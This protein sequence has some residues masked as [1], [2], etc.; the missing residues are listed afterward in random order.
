MR[1]VAG[2]TLLVLG[3]T[4]AFLAPFLLLYSV[5]RLE[6]A[7][8][9]TSENVVSD[10]VANY[11]SAKQLQ[12]VG[13]APVQV[14]ETLRGVP[15]K[16][17]TSVAVIAYRSRLVD[18]RTGD[19][20]SYDQETY[21]M[22]RHTGVAANCCGETPK[23]SGVTLKFPFGTQKATYQLWDPSANASFAVRY[24]RTDDL[25]G[26]SA[27]VFSGSSSDINIGTIDLPNSLVGV[28]GQGLTTE[29]EMYQAQTTVWIEPTT[30]QV[31]K[32]EKH[33]HQWAA[34]SSGTIVL[35]L[36]DL[37]VIY[38]DATVSRFVNDA[39]TNVQQLK[40][41]KQGIPLFG[42]ILGLVLAMVGLL[43][44]RRTPER[45]SEDTPVATAA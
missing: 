14:V 24:A 23:M 30:G 2:Y 8:T 37:H 45:A 43:L 9:D 17:T 5:P 6:K 42:G 25:K 7:P 34:D 39:K 12:L 22:N 41:V 44:L 13:P 40:L 35:E 26:I 32:G 3:L 29:Q 33:V 36:A 4:L 20:I 16:G 27:Y 31:L 18:R 1:R 11:F 28:S 19:P 10:G 38:D 15:S 21:A